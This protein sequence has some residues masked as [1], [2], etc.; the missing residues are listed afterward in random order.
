MYLMRH[1]QKKQNKKILIT[2]VAGFI[3]SHLAGYAVKQNYR[4]IGI[5]RK[6]DDTVN[7]LP[8]A[9][10]I[11]LI[12]GDASHQTFL[13]KVLARERPHF[14]FHLASLLT[15]RKQSNIKK[16]GLTPEKILLA[17]LNMTKAL[18]ES[19]RILTGRHA[20]NPVIILMG[21]AEE[22]G[23][24]KKLPIQESAPLHPI[25]HYAASK[26][27][28]ELFGEAYHKI[29]GLK[30][31]LVRLFNQHGPRQQETI[32]PAVFAK[33]IAAIEAGTQEPAIY[34]GNLAAKRDFTDV[35][36]TVRALIRL[37]EK[38]NT[39]KR[40]L[41]TPFNIA[42]G[43]KHFYSIKQILNMLLSLSQSDIH[44]QIDPKR[45]RKAEIPAVLG[46]YRKLH[47]AIKWQP[48][49]PIKKTLR[50]S[51]NYWRKRIQNQKMP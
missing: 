11:K 3:G 7:I 20:Y 51:L 26:V 44:T 45:M 27:L 5:K 29:Y 12:T 6:N 10:K 41:G 31:I 30:I 21:S 22:Y 42:G 39:D 35:R 48:N 47:T 18:L 9:K 40:V 8:I 25:T 28:Q 36:D 49:I 43:K 16:T 19:A 38:A 37:A 34:H 1:P 14:I 2:G 15:P 24:I 4:V 17:N 46:S 32:V 50:D 33:Q 13:T 23:K